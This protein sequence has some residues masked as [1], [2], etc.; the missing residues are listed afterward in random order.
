[1]RHTHTQR[2]RDA[3]TQAEGEVDSMQG[4]RRGTRSRD[5]RITPWAKGR[6]STTEPPRDPNDHFKWKETEIIWPR[7]SFVSG[8]NRSS[9]GSISLLLPFSIPAP[10]E[11]MKISPIPGY[12]YPLFLGSQ[13]RYM[14]K[15]KKKRERERERQAYGKHRKN[16]RKLIWL[17]NISICPISEKD[18]G[19]KTL[20][21]KSHL[22][23]CINP[24]NIVTR[25][26]IW[27]VT[28]EVK[29]NVRDITK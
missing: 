27:V 13:W 1:M 15:K 7:H 16:K 19:R 20:D 2:E 12:I 4:A 6:R 5:S 8:W 14:I 18:W 9:P 17:G 25:T 21:K 3:E 26:H 28:M 23:Y 11:P 22:V 10:W 29:K 24:N